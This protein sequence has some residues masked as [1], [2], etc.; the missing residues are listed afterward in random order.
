MK[1]KYL[2]LLI[3]FVSGCV[4]LPPTPQDIEARKFQPLADKAVIYIVRPR[5][6]SNV[7]GPV[8]IP[9]GMISTYQGTYYRLEV[10]PGLQRIEGAG[11][12]TAAVAINA[13]AGRIYFVEHTVLGTTREGLLSMWLR[14]IDESRGRKMVSEAT[15][16]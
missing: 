9:G 6:D 1:L 2:I 15:L 13:E 11:A 8:S 12:S 3:F 7:Q 14:R 16:L 5:V 4:Q 10:L